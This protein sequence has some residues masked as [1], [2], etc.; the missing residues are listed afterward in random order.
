MAIVGTAFLLTVSR[1]LARIHVEHDHC[2]RSPLVHLRDPLAG[3]IDER[4]KVLQ[5]TKPLRLE[6]AHLAGRS[7][8][9]RNR[10]VAHYPARR[11][12]MAQALGVV[13]VLV[14]SQ[15]PT[16]RLPQ[17]PHK[18]MA[19][20]FCRCAHQPVYW[21]YVGQAQRVV[22]PRYASSP[23]SEVITRARNCSIS[24]VVEIESQ[25]FTTAQGRTATGFRRARNR[26][27]QPV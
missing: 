26:L 7:G 14:A 5:P 24:P 15:P 2:R 22:K 8:K 6:P 21:R 9:A 19:T 23:P 18:P 17:Q 13:H 16:Y 3:Q 4:C 1:A 10:P 27:S 25:S 11:R 20:V 12:I